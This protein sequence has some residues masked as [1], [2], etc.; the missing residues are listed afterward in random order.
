ML[1]AKTL[2]VDHRLAY[3]GTANFDYR[4]F[5][6]NFELNVALWGEQANHDLAAMF[7]ADLAHCTRVPRQRRLPFFPRLA[8]ASARLLAPL[9]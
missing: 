5:M 1:H 7:E 3:I 6:L 2:L 9:L 8:E 4:S